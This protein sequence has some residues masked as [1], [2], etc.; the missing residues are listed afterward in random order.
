MAKKGKK[1][2]S[3]DFSPVAGES[4][5]GTEG[6]KIRKMLVLGQISTTPAMSALGRRVYNTF[7]DS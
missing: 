2:A 6:Q 5:M 4:K 7:Y 1:N 3:L